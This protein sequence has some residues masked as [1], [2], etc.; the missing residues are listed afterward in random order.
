ML[1]ITQVPIDPAL[2]DNILHSSLYHLDD[3]HSSIDSKKEWVAET[4]GEAMWG[5]CHRLWVCFWGLGFSE[6]STSLYYLKIHTLTS[7]DIIKLTQPVSLLLSP[8]WTTVSFTFSRRSSSSATATLWMP[9]S[10]HLQRPPSLTAPR[11]TF[12]MPHSGLL[13]MH[14]LWLVHNPHHHR[15]ETN[16]AVNIPQ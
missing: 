12:K 5:G 16:M 11:I 10:Q 14:L 15:C 9:S 4:N 8:Q 6:E 3:V 1:L 7:T 13:P 2:R